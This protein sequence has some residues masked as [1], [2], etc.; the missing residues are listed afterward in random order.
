MEAKSGLD[1][2][3]RGPVPS[4][5]AGMKVKGRAVLPSTTW[6]MRDAEEGT[7]EGRSSKSDDRYKVENVMAISWGGVTETMDANT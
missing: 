1:W 7:R 4:P 2:S 3:G 5:M 6:G